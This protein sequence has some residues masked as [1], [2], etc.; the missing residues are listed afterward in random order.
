M[1]IIEHMSYGKLHLYPSAITSPELDKHDESLR[2]AVVW[3]REQDADNPLLLS[4]AT[5]EHVVNS[6]LV[7]RLERKN[8][9]CIDTRNRVSSRSWRGPVVG[10]GV[11]WRDLHH[12]PFQD[13]TAVCL[14]PWGLKGG[15][16][17][18][19]EVSTG[20]R[21]WV[22]GTRASA[23]GGMLSWSDGNTA[24]RALRGDDAEFMETWTS[25]IN[26]ANPLTGSRE[27][28]DLVDAL[29]GL[30]TRVGHLDTDAL[31]AWAWSEGWDGRHISVLRELVGQINA[32]KKIQVAR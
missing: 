21:P 16:P 13:A 1:S 4:V 2:E 6:R 25:G 23:L 17:K 7:K 14:T 18:T 30:K 19:I 27:K 15:D 12:V 26:F 11:N 8:W 32:G 28:R 10:V 22:T 5:R 31:E 29:N 3:A 24:D 20:L 9:V